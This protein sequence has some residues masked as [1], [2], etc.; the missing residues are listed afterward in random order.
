MNGTCE[1]RAR[2]WRGRG[3]GAGEALMRARRAS[4]LLGCMPVVGATHAL[5]AVE[6]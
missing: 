1:D 6:E 5:P 4:P 2:H 3:I